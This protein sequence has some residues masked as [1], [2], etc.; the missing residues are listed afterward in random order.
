MKILLAI[1]SR[2]NYILQIDKT[3][4]KMGHD[5][6]VVYTD[7]YTQCCSYI[8]KKMD[9]FGFK[10]RRKIFEYKWKENLSFLLNNFAPDIFLLVNLPTHILLADDFKEL[11]VKVKI[12][13]WFVD[14]I[15][16]HPEYEIYYKYVAKVAVFELQE[17]EYLKKL[18]VKNVQYV[19]VGYNSIYGL[20]A[21]SKKTIDISFVGSP[22][23]NRLEIL[24]SV[25]KEALQKGWRLKIYGPFYEKRYIWKKYLLK[26][27]YPY[28]YKFLYNGSLSSF[29]V[30]EI[31]AKSKIVLNIHD[32]KH[33]S[34]NPRTFDILAVGVLEIC[35]LRDN[36]VGDLK[37]D[38]ALVT[39]ENIDELLKNIE[40]YLSHP[41][42]RENIAIYGKNNNMY[43]MEYSL[44]K[45]LGGEKSNE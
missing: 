25:A 42:E 1:Y 5:V 20:T 43:S 38:K 24:E 36:Y 16:D 41:L 18:N 11:S 28:L 4:V 2:N 13:I 8:C 22:F 39:F 7:E 40:F 32:L 10:S 14:G 27:R 17:V 26:Y 15:T 31:Y 21:V 19:P 3:L 30:A 6:R 9:K 23:K 45:I 33:R 12:Y 34:P 37:P 29:E 44:S 35:D